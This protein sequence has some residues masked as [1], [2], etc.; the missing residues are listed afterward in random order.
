MGELA[1][2]I[3]QVVLNWDIDGSVMSELSTLNLA[4]GVSVNYFTMPGAIKP[5]EVTFVIGEVSI[6]CNYSDELS[7]IISRFDS[8]GAI[9]FFVSLNKHLWQP[10]N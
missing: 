4:E 1:L 5:H 9:E 2:E 8:I 6:E 10:C 3:G 7:E